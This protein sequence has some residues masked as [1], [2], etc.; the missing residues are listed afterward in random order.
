MG[1]EKV[2]VRLVLSTDR[3]RSSRPIILRAGRRNTMFPPARARPQFTKE[4][5]I[6]ESHLQ[7][8]NSKF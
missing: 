6:V 2:D 8:C 3:E 5:Q 1:N 7:S 4:F